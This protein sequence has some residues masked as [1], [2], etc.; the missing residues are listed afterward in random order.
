MRYLPNIHNMSTRRE[1]EGRMMTTHEF[2]K[3]SVCQALTMVQSPVLYIG[4]LH[5]FP[6]A[7]WGPA[8]YQNS[9]ILPP[10]SCQ[11]P[12]SSVKPRGS[13]LS[14]ELFRAG[15]VCS[16]VDSILSRPPVCLPVCLG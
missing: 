13:C 8:A 9:L 16:Y 4:S 6:I 1:P 3:A 12:S 10:R 5:I 7:L 11:G 14:A 15:V 2:L